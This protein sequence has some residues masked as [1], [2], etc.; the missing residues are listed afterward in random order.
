MELKWLEDLIC[1]AEKGHFAR[2]AD[3][4]H[5]TH[6]AL[7][8]RIKSLEAWT[9][10]ELLDRSQHPIRLTPAGQDFI[11]FASEI[12]QLSYDGRATANSFTRIAETGVTI[13][14]LHTLALVF[15]PR[16]IKTLQD[17]TGAFETSIVAETRTIDEYL[18]AL[19]NGGS[20]FFVCYVHP[21]KE[22]SIDTTDF[23]R[24]DIGVDYIRPYTLKSFDKIDTSD[25]AKE[26]IPYLEYGST[27]FL[28]QVVESI[29]ETAPYRNRLKP[30]FRATLAESL[31]TATRQAL[32]M[33]WLPDSLV[34]THKYADD[35][36]SLDDE[37]SLPLTIS[38]F[39]SA[40]NSRPIV[41]K[42]WAALPDAASQTS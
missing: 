15:L 35:L 6:S 8:R 23:P 17:T 20:D 26:P 33:A 41:E 36:V 14:S 25:A 31:A 37:R 4:R 22:L 39:R 18:E 16:L 2:A 34:K 12:V 24:L 19:H 32:G 40:A 29:I 3:A 5:I 13:A 27:A 38:I 21:T 7:S 30:V 9:G 28:S 1:V 42:I 10:A 11:T